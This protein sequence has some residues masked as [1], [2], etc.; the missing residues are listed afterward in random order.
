MKKNYRIVSV[1]TARAKSKRLPKKNRFKFQNQIMT[2]W[3]VKA[4]L[5]SK[6]IHET[7]LSTDDSYLIKNL[8][9]YPIKIH[10][11]KKKHADDY[12]DTFSVI[13]DVYYNFLNRNAD[14][15]VLLQPT[16]PLRE[17]NLLDKN[18]SDFIKKKNLSSMIELCEI[19]SPHGFI[20]NGY[21][22]S[23][24]RFKRSQDL[25]KSFIC[26]GRLYFYRCK[27]T[28]EKN[29]DL[30]KTS[31]PIFA[32]FDEN[33]NIDYQEDIKKLEMVYKFHKNKFKHLLK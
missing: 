25:S 14:I 24:T 18:L 15:I 10:H 31:Q 7:I 20:K 4:S 17:K 2:E 8:R 27:K 5:Q 22:K 3:S 30:G 33:I 21:F 13:K 1:I 29:H 32:N 26:S 23:T 6:L 16:S 11:R 12:S 9:K 19:K 28:I